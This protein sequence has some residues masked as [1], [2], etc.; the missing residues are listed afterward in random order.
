MHRSQIINQFLFVEGPKVAEKRLLP[1]M[2]IAKDRN[3]CP[4]H[5]SLSS[6]SVFVFSKLVLLLTSFLNFFLASYPPQRKSKLN[7]M[8]KHCF[9]LNGQQHSSPLFSPPQ[10][11]KFTQ[12]CL[13]WRIMSKWDLFRNFY[14]I[15]NLPPLCLKIIQN[16]SFEFF[17]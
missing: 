9:T 8:T 16:V 15:W 11:L 7:L 17:N 6:L 13:N 14:S 12:K 1:E 4:W 2:M 10:C 5:F 3:P